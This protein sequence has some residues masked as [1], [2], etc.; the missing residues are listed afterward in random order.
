M[1]HHGSLWPLMQAKALILPDRLGLG[2]LSGAKYPGPRVTY[3]N[4]RRS[5][6]PSF[7]DMAGENGFSSQ[8][9]RALGLVGTGITSILGR[10]LIIGHWGYNH[11]SAISLV[12]SPFFG[13]L[14]LSK[15]SDSLSP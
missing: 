13:G 7:W 5:H 9:L 8:D 3:Q 4:P 14:E 10:V 11:K 6:C 12:C 15:Q 1:A 2:N